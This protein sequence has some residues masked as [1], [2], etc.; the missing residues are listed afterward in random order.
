MRKVSNNAPID[1]YRRAI[2][3]YKQ[4]KEEEERVAKILKKDKIIPEDFEV[5]PPKPKKPKKKPKNKTPKKPVKKKGDIGGMRVYK[6]GKMSK[7]KP[8][9]EL[10]TFSDGGEQVNVKHFLA[11]KRKIVM[12]ARLLR[13][14]S[15]LKHGEK[16]AFDGECSIN[17]NEKKK[18][19][20]VSGQTA[21]PER[22]L[23][24]G[25]DA[26]ALRNGV[27]PR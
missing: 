18:R 3:A 15:N 25:V 11:G 20:R 26:R 8:I 7:M 23:A 22:V 13:S 27:R 10:V 14:L 21:R 5:R 24:W 16:V 6:S 17:W 2:E 19:L 12:D 9:E 4:R 1:R